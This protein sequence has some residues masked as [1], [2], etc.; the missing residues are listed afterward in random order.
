M[1][2]LAE[3][4]SARST[5]SAEALRRLVEPGRVHR[6]LYTD[7]QIFALEM[8]R[9]F[10]AGWV[11]VGHESQVRKPG[12]YVATRIGLKPIVLVRHEDGKVYALHNQCAH[13]GA[14]V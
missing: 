6:S 10:G 7:P 11:Y 13:R 14:M 2:A 3:V 8:E 9:I 4:S 5:Y 12:D 1:T